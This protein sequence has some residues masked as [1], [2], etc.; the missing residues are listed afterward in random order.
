MLCSFKPRTV[1]RAN[2][3]GIARLLIAAAI[4]CGSAALHAAHADNTVLDWNNEFLLVTQQTS[5]NLVTGPPEV[6]R[7]IAQIGEA[8]SDAVSAAGANPGTASAAAGAAAYTALTN[9]FT[10]PAWQTPISTING[11]FTAS[12]GSSNVNLANN[13]ILP[14]LKNFLTG[15]F[16]F[17]PTSGCGVSPSCAGYTIGIVAANT[18]DNAPST[19]PVASGAVAAIQNEI[20]RAHV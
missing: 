16:G 15:E 14:E 4:F 2:Y 9:I 6:A 20:G 3:P 8:M 10:D 13:V 17:D 12:N 5:G 19:S 18:V 1:P 7:E 11:N